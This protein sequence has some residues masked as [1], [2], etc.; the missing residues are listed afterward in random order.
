MYN[1]PQSYL[2]ISHTNVI[3]YHLKRGYPSRATALRAQQIHVP[4]MTVCCAFFQ[5]FHF[6]FV[7]EASAV[8]VHRL[9]FFS[10]AP[11]ERRRPAT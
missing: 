6:F 3:C 7:T 10:V 8:V 1:K 9:T 4:L 11:M 5:C 2:A